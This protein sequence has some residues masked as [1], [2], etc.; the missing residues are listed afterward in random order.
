MSSEF[1]DSTNL[2]KDEVHQVSGVPHNQV[3]KDSRKVLIGW[4][5]S[6]EG[7]KAFDHYVGKV[8]QAGDQ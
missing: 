7:N 2:E 3:N 1:K 4:K 5:N 8:A 6:P